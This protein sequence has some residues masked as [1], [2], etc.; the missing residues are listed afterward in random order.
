[1]SLYREQLDTSSDGRGRWAR[2]RWR[3]WAKNQMARLRR[4]QAK[5]DPTTPN[6]RP[7]HGYET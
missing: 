2:P 4:R 7:F 3:K 5:R 1:M 6:K